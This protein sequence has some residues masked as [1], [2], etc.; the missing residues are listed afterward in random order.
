MERTTQTD[1]GNSTQIL[2]SNPAEWLASLGDRLDLG[3]ATNQRE[4]VQE[5]LDWYQLSGMLPHSVHVAFEAARLWLEGPIIDEAT[6]ERA[7]DELET[8][9]PGEDID[10]PPIAKAVLRAA[11]GFT[12]V[13]VPS[14]F[15]KKYD[16]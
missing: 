13:S 4:Q 12:E 15:D 6:I 3:E 2:P 8:W 11:L 7:A 10:T 9:F 14:C 16:A 1:L 5:A